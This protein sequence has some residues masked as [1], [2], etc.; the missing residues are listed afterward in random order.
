M[1]K[2]PSSQELVDF[3]HASFELSSQLL[4]GI[5]STCNL[6]SLGQTLRL[7]N[8]SEIFLSVLER[9]EN[10]AIAN[11]SMF[12]GF[13]KP[14]SVPRNSDTNHTNMTTNASNGP[15]ASSSVPASTSISFFSL[16]DTFFSRDGILIPSDQIRQPLL[17]FLYHESKRKS[18]NRIGC[19]SHHAEEYSDIESLV[20]ILQKTE[21]NMLA[22]RVIL[23][24]SASFSFKNKKLMEPMISL[25]RKLLGY[26]DV[27]SSL[28]ISVMIALPFDQIVKE[29]QRALPSIQ[30]DFVRLQTVATLGEEISRLFAEENLTVF[31]QGLQTNAKWWHIF[32]G[33]GIKLD[34]KFFQNGQA[35]SSDHYIRSLVPI[36]FS[37]SNF[38]LPLTLEFCRQFHIEPE[39]AYVQYIE[40]IFTSKPTSPLDSSWL[41]QFGQ[42]SGLVEEKAILSCFRRILHQLH[43][44]DYEKINYVCRWLHNFLSDDI[45]SSISDSNGSSVSIA[46][47][48]STYQR[49][50]EMIMYLSTLQ[51][52]DMRGVPNVKFEDIFEGLTH[53]S[54]YHRLPVWIIL[55]DPWSVLEPLFESAMDTMNKLG[56]LCSMLHIDRDE[57]Q[58]RRIMAWYHKESQ[59][60]RDSIDKENHGS[61][62]HSFLTRIR[63]EVSLIPTIRTRIDL[64]KWIFEKER[65]RDHVFAQSA[66]E[67]AIDLVNR[68][69]YRHNNSSTDEME[70]E[71]E[72][73][74]NLQSNL[75]LELVKL[76]CERSVEE[77]STLIQSKFSSNSMLQL[78]TIDSSFF[79]NYLS[80]LEDMIKNMLDILVI[81]AWNLQVQDSLD[82]LFPYSNSV[83]AIIMR[84]Q[85]LPSVLSYLQIAGNL[86]TN[87]V[88]H[89]NLLIH[90][91]SRVF[92]LEDIRGSLISRLLVDVDQGNDV[93]KENQRS[94]LRNRSDFLGSSILVPSIAEIRRK[95]DLYMAFSCVALIVACDNGGERYFCYL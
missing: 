57:F 36:L 58:T 1:E 91:E 8:T 11:R 13:A 60:L 84:H 48:L 53:D 73:I 77:S 25:S 40:K 29:I 34:P 71:M 6:L 81:D 89:C 74:H 12:H 28:V 20:R 42:V 35:E 45:A 78:C 5:T 61:V 26:R 27:D 80:N 63:Q 62:C 46:N 33:K 47:E 7:L 49:Y 9:S 67:E 59:V 70:V 66:I 2:F 75:V 43:D 51:L 31:F 79:D 22:M 92:N 69:D 19:C 30:S 72:D 64:W 16:S 55:E 68:I 86:I 87:I 94:S 37:S 39:Y 21:N 44:L 54:Y 17:S 18:S 10:H 3:H 85:L 93:N 82:H 56:P 38:N 76:Q 50:S 83:F 23:G 4:M 52:K 90:N 88:Q 41:M 14:W 65:S 32:T 24:S 15:G 95:E